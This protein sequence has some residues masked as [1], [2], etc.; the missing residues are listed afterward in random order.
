[1]RENDRSKR[2]FI[3]FDTDVEFREFPAAK[4]V[5]RIV[6]Y[7]YKN[8]SSIGRMKKWEHKLWAA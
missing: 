7:S 3:I 1:M 8:G 2:L 6:Q 4:G 5:T